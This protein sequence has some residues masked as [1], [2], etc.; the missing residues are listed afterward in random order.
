MASIMMKTRSYDYVI[1]GGGSAGCVL[2]ARLTE[3]PNVSVA[4]LEAGDADKAPEISTPIAWPGLAKTKFDWDFASEPEPALNGRR[5]YIARGKTLG[6]SSAVN[7]M[8]YMRGNPMDYDGWANE[9][10]PGWSYQEI[11]PYFIKSERNQRGDERFHGRSGPLSV[12]DGR[13]KHPLVDRFVEAGIQAGHK[14]NDDFNGASQLGVGRLQFTM[15]DGSRWSAA[16]A[17]LH[18]ARQRSNLHVLTGVLVTRVL[19]EGSHAVGVTVS[20]YGNEE[21]NLG[22]EREVVLSAGAY[23]SPQILMLSGIGPASDLKR[24]GIAP[25]VDLPVGENLQDHPF[26]LPLYLTN[27]STFFRAGSAEDVGLYQRER[28]GPL[29]SGMVEAG[30][31]LTIRSGERVPDIEIQMAPVMYSDEGLSVPTDDA[32]GISADLLKPTSRGKVTLRSTRPDAKP[33]IFLNVLTTPEDRSTIIAGVR[34]I[35]HIAKQPALDAVRRSDLSVPRSESDADI[36][37]FV[38]QQAVTDRHPS[39]TCAMG[40]VVDPEL[41]VLGIEGLRVVDASVMPSITRGNLNA[42]VIA[43]AEKAADLLLHPSLSPRQLA[44]SRD[45]ARPSYVLPAASSVHF[46]KADET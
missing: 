19:L 29:A 20:R 25:I 35:L 16:D 1:I 12:Q 34:Q 4:L 22:A 6:G 40:R 26:V 27:E 24:F 17:Y 46:D 18:P 7:A 5:V 9:G 42:T 13:Y 11:L 10:A 15:R 14:H 30:G 8:I 3:D 31:F 2:A 41:K 38:Q 33:R 39:C 43:M 36:W 45:M 23:N 32:F 21:E 28:R 37:E 44:Q